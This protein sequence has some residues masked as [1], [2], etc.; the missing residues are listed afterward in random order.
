MDWQSIIT[1]PLLSE[2]PF[3]IELNA[4]G[5]VEMTPAT[6]LH[7]LLQ[8]TIA[9]LLRRHLLDGKVL[10]ECS[11]E[12]AKNIKV[13]A[14]AWCS[15]PLFA[16]HGYRMPYPESSE[17]VVEVASPSNRL[18]ELIEK[19]ELYSA[20]GVQEVWI[21]EETGEMRFARPTGPLTRPL[22]CP[23]FPERV[24]L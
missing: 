23:G 14:A 11:I 7:G 10:L 21:C 5:K 18:S 20:R 15:A 12:T 3:K 13:A 4:W 6:N 8:A 1:D 2:L 9:V 16:R 24:E 19:R 22:I 17:L